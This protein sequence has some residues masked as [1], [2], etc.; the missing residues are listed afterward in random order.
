MKLMI[1]ISFTTV[2]IAVQPLLGHK[3][4]RDVSCKDELRIKLERASRQ[5]SNPVTP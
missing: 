5:I 4:I 3:R 2:V 1:G